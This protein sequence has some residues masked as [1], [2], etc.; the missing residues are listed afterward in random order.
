VR[1][2]SATSAEGGLRVWCCR[3]EGW[4]MAKF[5]RGLGPVNNPIDSLLG[6]REDGD[7]GEAAAGQAGVGRRVCVTVLGRLGVGPVVLRAAEEAQRTAPVIEDLM[8]GVA[9]RRHCLV[10]FQI[11]PIGVELL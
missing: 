4:D 6:S 3:T 8:K 7:G 5:G 10:L 11:A 1:E 2:T 9:S